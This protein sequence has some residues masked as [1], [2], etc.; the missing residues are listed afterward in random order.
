MRFLDELDIRKVGERRWRLLSDFRFES[1]KYPG[2]FVAP[3][4]METNFA[5]IPRIAYRIL[6]PIGN[7][8]EAAVIHDGAYDDKLITPNGQRIN[9]VKHVADNLFLEAL[10]TE[11]LRHSK[12]GVARANLMYFL[13]KTFGK[14]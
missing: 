9:C 10:L 14:K 5:S 11:T 4:G 13:V 1:D 7:Y 8:D 12:V 2:I 6:P 3:K